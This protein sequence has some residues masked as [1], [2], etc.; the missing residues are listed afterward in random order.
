VEVV[1]LKAGKWL[2][3]MPGFQKPQGILFVPRL[4][5]VF[6]ASGDDG[7]VRVFSAKLC[8]RSA[9]STSKPSR[10]GSITSGNQVENAVA[11][12]KKPVLTRLC[13][14]DFVALGLQSFPQGLADLW[15]VF[16]DKESHVSTF[17]PV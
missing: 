13:K 2:R 12:K 9:A 16:D 1:D 8:L 6:V 15:F 4:V 14:N 10:P 7:M 3:T 5:K 17:L 11:G